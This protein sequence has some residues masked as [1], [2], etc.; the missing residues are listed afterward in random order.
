MKLWHYK[1]L[2]LELEEV[3]EMLQHLGFNKN[4]VLGRKNH[5]RAGVSGK[6][7]LTTGQT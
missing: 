6:I 3:I 1:R 2:G 7:A 4:I 5:L